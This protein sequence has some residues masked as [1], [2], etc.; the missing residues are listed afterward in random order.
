MKHKIYK[1]EALLLLAC[2]QLA[3]TGINAFAASPEFARSEEEWAML[4]DNK[5]E[6]K[7]IDALVNEYNATVLTNK[8]NFSKD[9]RKLMDAQDVQSYLNDQAADYEDM[10]AAAESTNAVLAAQLRAQANSARE[11]ADENVTDSEVLRLGYE[12]IEAGIALNVKTMMVDYYEMLDKKALLSSNAEYL[13]RQ[14]KSVEN[15]FNLGLATKVD[16]LNAKEAYDNVRAELVTMDAAI[17]QS[18]KNL[19]VLCGWKYDSQA[20]IAELPKTDLERIATINYEEDLKKALEANYTLKIDKIKLENAKTTSFSTSVIEKNEKQLNDDTDSVKLQIKS[21][22]DALISAAD[23]YKNAVSAAEIQKGEMQKA[24]TQLSLGM[25]SQMDY[26]KIQQDTLTKDAAQKTAE[27]NLLK[28]EVKY[29][30]VLRGVTQSQG[31]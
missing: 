21:S 1:T 4:R 5:L 28:A 15:K 20:E 30:G 27:R 16:V 10:A 25:I 23:A 22:Y 9:E 29:D 26:Y 13:E 7:E 18:Y 19:I 14:Y 8:H 31:Q 12:Q 2:T 17:D 24:E 6:W 11:Q 3:L